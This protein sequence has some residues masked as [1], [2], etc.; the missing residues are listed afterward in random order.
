[1]AVK[2]WVSRTC[3]RCMRPFGDLNVPYGEKIP[4]FERKHI[5][6]S[7]LAKDGTEQVLA[8]YKD[9]CESCGGTVDNYI[10]RI[11]KEPQEKSSE[12][13]AAPEG[14][15]KPDAE[16]KS[17]EG[18]RGRGRAKNGAAAEAPKEGPKSDSPF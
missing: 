12:A 2:V 14:E 6:I 10:K 13:G 8:E 16:A 1:M 4:E 18:A 7:S 5:K 3:D 17:E 11:R 9:L 15:S